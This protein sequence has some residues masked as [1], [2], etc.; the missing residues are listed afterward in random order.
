[1]FFILY[2]VLFLY[3]IIMA[4]HGEGEWNL[5]MIALTV[6]EPAMQVAVVELR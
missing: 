1:M 3:L 2:S 4:L 6:P 5:A